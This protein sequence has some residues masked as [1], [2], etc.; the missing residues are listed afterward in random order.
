MN[1]EPIKSRVLKF[2]LRET[3]YT[4]IRLSVTYYKI[5]SIGL[6][7]KSNLCIWIIVSDEPN[8]IGYIENIGIMTAYTGDTLEISDYD[9]Y[10]G[11]CISISGKVIHAFHITKP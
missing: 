5:L 6:D 7:G 4:T 3:G 11:T 1:T 8:T 2:N 9:K 10:I